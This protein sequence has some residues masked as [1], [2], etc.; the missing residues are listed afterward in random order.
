MTK[1][2]LNVCGKERVGLLVVDGSS[3]TKRSCDFLTHKITRQVAVRC[4]DFRL[5]SAAVQ[6]KYCSF[7]VLSSSVLAC[8]ASYGMAKS[9]RVVTIRKLHYDTDE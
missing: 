5:V 2:M 9:T 3:Q 8:R 4:I 6:G 7:P 1:D